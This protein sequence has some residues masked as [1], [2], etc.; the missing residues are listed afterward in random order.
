MTVSD[1]PKLDP[2]WLSFSSDS[3]DISVADLPIWFHSN[4]LWVQWN[5][6]LFIYVQYVFIYVIILYCCKIKIYNILFYFI[7]VVLYIIIYI[8][9]INVICLKKSI[10]SGFRDLHFIPAF[11]LQ[12]AQQLSRSV[13]CIS[14]TFGVNVFCSMHQITL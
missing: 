4:Y 12:S 6:F 3:K 2:G 8:F 5:M 7:V 10:F 13:N 1:W 11:T 9:Y 14:I